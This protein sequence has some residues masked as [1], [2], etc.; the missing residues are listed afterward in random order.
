M[1]FFVYIYSYL[2]YDFIS[3]MDK[4][5]IWEFEVFRSV[6]NGLPSLMGFWSFFGGPMCEVF[7]G[8]N[9]LQVQ[10]FWSFIGGPMCE[11]FVVQT[12]SKSDG[13]FSLTW[14][15]S[16]P[17]TWREFWP[18]SSGRLGVKLT[19]VSALNLRD[20]GY[21]NNVLFCEILMFYRLSNN[22]ELSGIISD[23]M[24]WGSKNSRKEY[25]QFTSNSF[26]SRRKITIYLYISF[27]RRFGL[28]FVVENSVEFPHFD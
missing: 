25:L 10:W 24:G 19:K 7:R 27:W 20:W 11:D 9:N 5:D 23:L 4:N 22:L 2:F 16:R 26:L 6:S 3:P 14:Q 17:Q 13:I 21:L 1:I 8:P 28:Q 18:W 12:A 15:R